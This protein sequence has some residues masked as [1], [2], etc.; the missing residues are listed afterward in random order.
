MSQ[1][2][3]YSK[4]KATPPEHIRYDFDHNVR[5]RIAAIMQQHVRNLDRFARDMEHTIMVHYGQLYQ[6]AFEPA[7]RSDIPAIEHFFR[8]PDDEVLDF[9]EF[10][11]RTVD[12]DRHQQAVDE[13]NFVFE[14]VGIGFRFSDFVTLNPSMIP[15]GKNTFRPN[16]RFPEAHRITD[17]HVYQTVVQ[18]VL[19]FLS[20]ARFSVTCD[21]LMKA[22]A[23][24]R[25][26]QTEDAITLAGA[27]YESCLKTIMSIKGW[28]Y[29]DKMTCAKLV[30]VLSDRGV[31]PSFYESCLTSPG[32]IRN[33]LSD[34][35]GRGPEKV[36]EPQAY[37][38]DHTINLVCT[39]VLFLK[40][41]AGL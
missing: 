29:D 35:H 24:A 14:D 39:N 11:F 9:L 5:N 36:N 6:P 18:P 17:G 41:C 26:S 27:A 1:H 2:K 15:V 8:S 20:D 33:K 22:M 3:P 23:A 21:E 4:R 28:T 30:Q 25:Q 40:S 37:H 10:A 31:V 12:F 38:A 19:H 16:V 34:A 7:R 32:T 13:I